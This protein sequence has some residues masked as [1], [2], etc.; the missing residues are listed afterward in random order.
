MDV[1]QKNLVRGV[2]RIVNVD[3][4]EKHYLFIFVGSEHFNIFLVFEV[5]Q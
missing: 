3:V 4:N 5:Q 2:M 1:T